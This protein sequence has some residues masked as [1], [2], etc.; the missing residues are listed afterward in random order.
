MDRRAFRYLLPYRRPLALI[1]LISVLSTALSLFLPYLT[2]ILVDDALIARSGAALRQTVL[3]FLAAA[4]AGFALSV[5][6][7]LAYARLSAEILFDMRR[8]VY[9]HLQRL[10]PRFWASTRLGDVVSR[11]NS[12]V[13]E[14][15]RIVAETA[16]AWFGNTLFLAGSIVVLV[17]LDWRLFLIG[18][19][20]LPPAAWAL[21]LYRR[22]LERRTKDLRERSADLGSFLIETLQGMRTVLTSG[23]DVR[24]VARFGRLN[25]A[26]IATLMGVQRTHY[27]WGSVPSILVAAG[28]GAVFIY[29]G[30]R[31]IDGTMTLGTLLAFLAYQARMVAPVQAIMG[32]YGA[33]AT[34]RVSWR[35]VAA[36]LDTPPEV[37]ERPDAAPLVSAHGTLEFDAVSLAHERGAVLDGVSFRAGAGCTLAIVGSS[38]SGKSTIADLAV[39]LLDPDRGAVRLD[40]RDLT[41]L[42]LADL[43]RFVHAVPQEP[44]LFHGTIEDN[45]RYARPEA[46]E[47]DVTS[48]LASAGLG[49][50]VAGLPD[51]RR[52]IV[53]DRG[54]ALSAGERQR[55]ALARAFLADPAVLVL[56]EPSAALDP[57]AERLIVEGYR[58]VMRG[59]TVILITHRLDL[60]RAADEV[61]VLDGARIVERGTPAQVEAGGG[62]FAALF[63]TGGRA[64][65]AAPARP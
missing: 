52:T 38:G 33:L 8:D 34:A 37:V 23:A 3:L 24:E 16:L 32:L 25:D 15:Q 18:A 62:A 22:R 50:F 43:R 1:V 46:T 47:A 64:V 61:V 51:G 63:A 20:A 58:R 26:F 10:S 27:L 36:L 35:R 4:V 57:V 55:I 39:R 56:D 59:R 30:A 14:I 31:V 42:R 40:G 5:V 2:K 11:I 65:P 29:G 49:A 17:W 13:G 54:L 9:E 19:A 53:G 44:T 21:V 60:V 41:S 12:D 45:V 28:T 6:S 7:G 48:A